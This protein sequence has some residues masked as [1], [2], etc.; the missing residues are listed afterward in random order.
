MVALLI[1]VLAYLLVIVEEVTHFRKSRPV[2]LAASMIRAII[3]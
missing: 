2:I 1:F 3:A